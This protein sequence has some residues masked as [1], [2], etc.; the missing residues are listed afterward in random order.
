MFDLITIGD[1]TMDTFVIIN[2]A[3]KK[4]NL[5]KK[6]CKLCLNYADKIPITDTAQSV[7]GNANN[8]AVGVRKTGLR[9]S[10][11][12]ELGDDIYGFAI[13]QALDVARVDTRFVKMLKGKE[14]RYSVILNYKSERTILSYHTP[15]KYTFPKIPK[16]K[17]IY[18][19]SLGKNFEKLQSKLITYLKKHPET[20]LA[21]NPGSFQMKNK[22]HF[23]KI[24]PYI[25]VLILNK[26]EATRLV[27]K[28]KNI[29]LTL[30][31]LIKLGAKT[32]VITD[33]GK[34]SYATDGENFFSLP[35]SSV[36]PVAKTGAGDAYTSGFLSAMI[37]NKSI[38]AAMQWGTAN[39]SGVIQKF[40][41]QKGLLN[42][43]QIKKM[44]K[45]KIKRLPKKI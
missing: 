24:L 1:S 34:G 5:Q 38:E 7:G 30:K 16:T 10:I 13:L 12:T 32:T 31:A 37:R 3:T 44:I 45:T 14:T 23:K 11:V 9:T 2:D 41:A 19:T 43:R 33:G 28:K 39:S 36:K 18:Y 20:K 26:E 42:E 6:D 40:G 29:K 4:C 8:V 17:W 21:S 35:A 25:E 15:R 22:Q 27:G